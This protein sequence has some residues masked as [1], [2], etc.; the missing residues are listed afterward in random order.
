MVNAMC[1]CASCLVELNFPRK[2]KLF[3]LRRPLPCFRQSPARLYFS[4]S[5]FLSASS[6]S[7]ARG[8][9]GLGGHGGLNLLG[10]LV[11]VCPRSTLAHWQQQNRGEKER[12][13]R[14]RLSSAAALTHLQTLGTTALL[15]SFRHYNV[16]PFFVPGQTWGS[17]TS[18]G[19]RD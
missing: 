2:S 6:R 1:G 11:F 16:V 8:Q 4:L 14:V 12:P 17:L 18:L 19:L 13:P 7:E 9:R 15:P 3:S 10:S 5:V